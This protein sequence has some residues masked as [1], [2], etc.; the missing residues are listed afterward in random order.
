MCLLP[1]AVDIVAVTML[2]RKMGISSSRSDWFHF[3]SLP[4]FF[5]AVHLVAFLFCHSRVSAFSE[6][7]LCAVAIIGSARNYPQTMAL[8]LHLMSISHTDI[9]AL[10]EGHRLPHLEILTHACLEVLAQFIHSK[11]INKS[12]RHSRLSHGSLKQK[13]KNTKWLLES[14]WSNQEF[15][16]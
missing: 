9:K 8:V 4:L 11:V 2:K 13:L 10:V 5:L 6:S 16:L 7:S 14:L 15:Y 12:K 3:T 1:K